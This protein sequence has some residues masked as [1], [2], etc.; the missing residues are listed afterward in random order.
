MRGNFCPYRA[1]VA[2]NH[3]RHCTDGYRLRKN[4][5]EPRCDKSVSAS[6]NA[7]FVYVRKSGN[8]LSA[9]IGG[10]GKNAESWVV[11]TITPTLSSV[12]NNVLTFD[13]FGPTEETTP[14]SPSQETTMSPSLT[15]DDVPAFR[16]R[17]RS[18]RP[19]LAPP[20]LRKRKKTSARRQSCRAVFSDFRFRF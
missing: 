1:V 5:A 11:E 4:A 18:N 13:Q 6:E 14:T 15:P 3:V 7:V 8:T 10:C 16:F 2:A 17:Y 19:S 12:S 9:Q 20:H